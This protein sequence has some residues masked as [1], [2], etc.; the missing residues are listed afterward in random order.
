MDEE[1]LHGELEFE[2]IVVATRGCFHLFGKEFKAI[3]PIV[4]TTLFCLKNPLV[5]GSDEQITVVDCEN[6]LYL[7]EASREELN[8]CL[9]NPES[10]IGKATGILEKF[11]LTIEQFVEYHE[12][13]M[14]LAF[15]PLDG[16]SLRGQENKEQ[17][18]SSNGASYDLSWVVSVCSRVSKQFNE[19]IDKTMIRPLNFVSHGL[20]SW[21]NENGNLSRKWQAFFC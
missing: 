1:S 19:S 4:M 11:G 3:S 16:I 17:I 14:R 21:M 13:Q 12:R 20:V 9:L 15:L 2:E 5:G 6:F 8:E 10:I 7:C 18:T